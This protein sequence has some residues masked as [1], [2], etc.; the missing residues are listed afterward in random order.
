MP[1]NA[2]M[3]VA[4]FTLRSGGKT[5]IT[6]LFDSVFMWVVSIP[7][8]YTLSRYTVI[9]IVPLYF[10]CQMVEIIKCIVGFV[11]V[12]KGVWIHNIVLGQED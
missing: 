3:N 1:M 2:F 5:F 11:L 6:F 12:K 4:Y 9:P 7:V 8:A 10:M